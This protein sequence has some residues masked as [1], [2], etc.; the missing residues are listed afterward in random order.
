[1]GAVKERLPSPARRNPPRFDDGHPAASAGGNGTPAARLPDV[2]EP[3]HPFP[4]LAV[5]PA[6]ASRGSPI[7][8]DSSRASQAADTPDFNVSVLLLSPF[9]I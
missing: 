9:P 4:L 8:R 1:V 6:P 7:R 2:A 5:S 3:V